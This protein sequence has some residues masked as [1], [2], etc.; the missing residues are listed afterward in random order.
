ME[1]K[2]L[3]FLDNNQ[4][5]T[6]SRT[7]AEQFGKKHKHVLDA[8]RE[9]EQQMASD[10]QS[11]KFGSAQMFRETTYQA[12]DGGRNY[13]VYVMNRDG[14][15][16]LAMG[17][18]GKKALQFKL[19]FIDAFNRMEEQLKRIYRTPQIER[20][21]HWNETRKLG[22][23]VRKSFTNAIKLLED[24]LASRG[25]VY[26]KG[27]LYGH[28]TNVIQNALKI[29]KGS[30][31][32]QTAKK[33]NQLDQSED[34]AENIITNGV[35]NSDFKS[36]AEVE[37]KI[38]VQLRQL[39]SLLGGHLFIAAPIAQLDSPKDDTGDIELFF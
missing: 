30:R 3:V 39:N 32:F 1:T 23:Q 36:L 18:T 12:E 10:S 34:I 28:L 21:P 38:L 22:K 15:S 5:L 26:P 35:A 33:L 24:Y 25:R 16:L 13:P 20:D 17:F 2:A 29:E 4:A 7:V 9:I 27:Y 19:K 31:D 6:D 8:I 14:F 37:A 11:R